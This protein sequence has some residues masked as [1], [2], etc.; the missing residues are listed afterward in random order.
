VTF[1]EAVD[2]LK[3]LAEE[4]IVVEATVWGAEDDSYQLASLGGL[5]AYAPRDSEV[6]G[7]LS[8]ELRDA[9]AAAE[10]ATVFEVGGSDYTHTFALW[11]SRFVAAEVDDINGIQIV[12]RDGRLQIRKDRPWID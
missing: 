1:A 4:G 12:T 7:A 6:L 3:A 8:G 10:I 5:L 2:A 9:V 11:P